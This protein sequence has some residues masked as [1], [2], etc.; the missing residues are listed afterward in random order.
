MESE[1]F[2][3]VMLRLRGRIR[4]RTAFLTEFANIS[5]RLLLVRTLV[6]VQ[7]RGKDR[8][9]L[10]PFRLAGS[11]PPILYLSSRL[12]R[13]GGKHAVNASSSSAPAAEASPSRTE[14]LGRLTFSSPL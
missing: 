14:P 6:S 4:N 12:S 9:F 5:L 11:M 1:T 2:R 7:F 13:D 3:M 10:P 8:M